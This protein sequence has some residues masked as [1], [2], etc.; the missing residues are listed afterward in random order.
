[1]ST[2]PKSCKHL[3][4]PGAK[5]PQGQL[6][7][8]E[9]SVS[10]ALWCVHGGIH[11]NRGGTKGL[12]YAGMLR[13]SQGILMDGSPKSNINSYGKLTTFQRPSA[14]HVFLML[15]FGYATRG[16]KIVEKLTLKTYSKH[17]QENPRI[18]PFFHH[19]FFTWMFWKSG[20]WNTSFLSLV[21]LPGAE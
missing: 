18:A 20:S 8:R 12:M 2:S 4:S 7:S 10:I 3:Q 11:K 19:F 16:L 14:G 9:S 15:D 13:L 21:F 1:M 6:I 5:E 17:L